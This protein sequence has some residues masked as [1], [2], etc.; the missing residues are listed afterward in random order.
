MSLNHTI[1]ITDKNSVEMTYILSLF[2]IELWLMLMKRHVH[3]QEKIKLKNKLYPA[4]KNN[5]TSNGTL[6]INQPF[7]LNTIV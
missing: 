5:K 3:K 6:E 7:A 4:I 2:N 1:K